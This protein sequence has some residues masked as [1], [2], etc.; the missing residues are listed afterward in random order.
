MLFN[1]II[2]VPVIWSDDV[3][4]RVENVKT[5]DINSD[6]ICGL[7]ND[8]GIYVFNFHPIHLYLNTETDRHY[9]KSKR[10]YHDPLRLMRR[11]NRN[12]LGIL[13]LFEKLMDGVHVCD[14]KPFKFITI[15][16][17]V[18]ENGEK[19]PKINYKEPVQT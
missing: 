17:W 9:Q 1:G 19:I 10:Y 8:Q 12:N 5:V 7:F 4:L 15:K 2:E 13:N 16:Q 6:K 11:V 18:K 3:A 14:G